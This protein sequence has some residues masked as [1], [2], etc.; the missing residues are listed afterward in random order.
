MTGL[1]T[2]YRIIIPLGSAKG[3]DMVRISVKEY[4]SAE[5][6]DRLVDALRTELR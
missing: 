2:K 6:L 4:N 1:W 5:D 3:V